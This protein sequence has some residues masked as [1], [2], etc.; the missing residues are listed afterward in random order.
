MSRR[1]A[2]PPNRGSVF[3]I[4]F[5]IPAAEDACWCVLA[6]LPANVWSQHLG[7]VRRGGSGSS[8]LPAGPDHSRNPTETWRAED[9]ASRIETQ[10]RTGFGETMTFPS[11]YLMYICT[12]RLSE[13]KLW[14][15]WCKDSD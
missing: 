14:N 11:A 6:P 9:G 4:W 1:A 10:T 3:W 13:C 8:V 7:H 15:L 5:Q 12:V 2:F